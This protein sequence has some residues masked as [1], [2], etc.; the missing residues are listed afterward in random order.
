MYRL[1]GNVAEREEAFGIVRQPQFA[2]TIVQTLRPLNLLPASD[3]VSVLATLSRLLVLSLT[4]NDR[5]CAAVYAELALLVQN[6]FVTAFPALDRGVAVSI[7]RG[8]V[9]PPLSLFR[10]LT[11]YAPSFRNVDTIFRCFEIGTCLSEMAKLDSGSVTETCSEEVIPFVVAL[12]DR[13]LALTLAELRTT[14]W[15]DISAQTATAESILRTVLDFPACSEYIYRH[16]FAL[17]V[18]AI[19]CEILEY[20]IRGIT[21]L[22]QLSIVPL[23]PVRRSE[24]IV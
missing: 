23:S 7:C 12:F 17:A 1:S 18:K 3:A 22:N 5:Q 6:C 11:A 19:R 2:S 16:R 8:L 15:Q 21:E 4:D 10:T 20:R 14:S 13:I 9:S 24:S